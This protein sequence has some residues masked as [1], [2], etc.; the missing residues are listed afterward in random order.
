MLDINLGAVTRFPDIAFYGGI[1]L[2]EFS[3]Y[4]RALVIQD[5]AVHDYYILEPMG[6]FAHGQ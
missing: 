2:L 3:N 5:D 6:V 4:Q 1:Y